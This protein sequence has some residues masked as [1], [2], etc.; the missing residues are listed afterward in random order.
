[1]ADI[2]KIKLPDGTT[3]NLK[4]SDASTLKNLLDGSAAGSLR[5]VGSAEEDAN[6]TIGNYSVAIGHNTK[7]SG[8][9]SFAVGENS[10]ASGSGSFAGGQ[11]VASSSQAPTAS[12]DSSISYGLGT[13]ASGKG[14]VALGQTNTASGAAAT[15]VGLKNTASGG[16]AFAS[17][18]QNVASGS[19][20]FATGD[21]TI[22]NHRDQF[23]FGKYN[24]ADDSAAAATAI[25][26]Y[27]EIVGN[28][29]ADNARSNA[30]TLDWNGNEIL[31][32]KLTLGAGP[33]AAMD[34]ITKQYLEAQGYLTLATLPIYDG[35]VTTP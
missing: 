27:V 8:A 34:A 10:V 14:A 19:L 28:G 3:Y 6:Y 12:G 2:S 17:G 21:R 9:I 20:S 7:A 5:A 23:V 29:T 11:Y 22:A 32:G 26:N 31:A 13:I 35:T 16:G 25:G 30:R 4:D 33:T 1:M 18:Q 15:A 24:V